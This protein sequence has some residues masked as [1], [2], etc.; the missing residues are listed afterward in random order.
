MAGQRVL[1]PSIG[2]RV[3]VPQL[4]RVWIGYPIKA[5]IFDYVGSI[6]TARTI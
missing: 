6:P 2:V 5:Y 3:P 1:V 4:C